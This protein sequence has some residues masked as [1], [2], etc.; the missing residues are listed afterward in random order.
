MQ[1]KDHITDEIKAIDA[2]L[3]REVMEYFWST[4]QE[5]MEST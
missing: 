5:C 1:L 4:L 3:L 2:V